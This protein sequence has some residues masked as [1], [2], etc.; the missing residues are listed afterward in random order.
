MEYV[1]NDLCVVLR[2]CPAGQKTEQD[3]EDAVP[4][5]VVVNRIKKIN[6]DLSRKTNWFSCFLIFFIIYFFFAHTT[7]INPWEVVV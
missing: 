4:Y 1:G 7:D 3:V 2:A 5:R 6:V